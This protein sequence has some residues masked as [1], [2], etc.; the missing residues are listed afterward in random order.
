MS[1]LLLSEAIQ[2]IEFDSLPPA[3]RTFDLDRFSQKKSLWPCQQEALKSALKVLWRYFDHHANYSPNEAPAAMAAR[4]R[5]FLAW[6]RANGLTEE[7]DIPVSEESR[8]FPLISDYLKIVDETIAYD[9][10]INRAGFWMAT[11]SGKSLVL[12]KLIE[13]LWLLV[14]RGEIPPNDILVLTCREDLIAQLKTLVDEFNSGHSAFKIQLRELREFPEAKRESP[15]LFSEME[16]TVFYYRS[17]NLSS[18]QKEKIV[19]FRNYDDDGRWYVLLDEA[20][21]GDRED[22][23]RQHIYSILA[24]NGF[25]FNFSATFADP[26]DLVTTAF[27]F[28][29]SEFTKSGFGKHIS[30]LHQELHAFRDDEDFDDQEKQ[31]IV[32][33][34]LI[35]LTYAGLTERRLA[36]IAAGMY[37]RPLLLT[38]VNSVNTAYSDLELFFAQIRRIAIGEVNSR[39]WARAKAEL[40][41]E[42]RQR[43]SVMFEDGVR[44]SVN[45][46]TYNGIRLPDVLRQVFNAK[47][48]GEIEVIVRPSNNQEIAFKLRTSD[49][50]FAL[51]KIGDISEWLEEKLDGF[52]VEEGFSDEAYFD[53]LNASDSAI[54]ILMGSRSFYEGW[55]SN[56]PNVINFINVGV[57]V[58]SRKFIL[59]AIGR[60]VRVEPIQNLRRRLRP[61][62]NSGDISQKL[63]R[64]IADNVEPLETLFIFGTNRKALHAVIN[65]L[66]QE[67][68]NVG[69]HSI[70]LDKNPLVH[71]REL[72]IP[73][74]RESPPSLGESQRP[75]R[76]EIETAEQELLSRYSNFIGDDRVMMAIHDLTPEMTTRL[77]RSILSPIDTFKHSDRTYG[78]I[79]LLVKH[80]TDYLG[81]VP[82]EFDS[83]FPVSTEICHFENIAVY[84]SD[85]GELK[86]KIENVRRHSE[87]AAAESELD[88]KL[89]RKTI[90]LSKFK[91][92]IKRLAELVRE[93]VVTYRDKRLNIKN[94]A[95]HYYIPLLMSG[96]SSRLDYISHVVQEESEVRFLNGLDQYLNSPQNKFKKF[97]WWMFSKLDE[98]LDRIFIPYYDG[99]MNRIREFVPDFIFWLKAG[100]N[101]DIV[102]VD[103]KGTAHTDYQRKIDGFAKLFE[104]KSGNPKPLHHN[105][106]KV[107][108][109]VF[110]YTSDMDVLPKLYRKYWV[111]NL[112]SLLAQVT[113]PK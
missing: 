43:P 82:R 98:T 77:R 112:D 61:L 27:N 89:K 110:L 94:V 18:E 52:E 111:D 92:G 37:H 54:N 102:F 85:V 70:A 88:L 34:S 46:T 48:H 86:R 96:E 28:N 39:T 40:W 41:E 69:Y 1:R 103:P 71:G 56:R 91:E 36:R 113:R 90:S 35:M 55:D 58:E 8:H 87:V 106:L 60:G 26:R 32:L 104:D 2:A 3:W 59:Q 44:L 101:Y 63:F 19:D 20:H 7:L 23:K 21:K 14:S 84:V 78:D 95:N 12:I 24:R 108:I 72:L 83:L 13:I 45:E 75:G 25:L 79:K 62:F 49:R 50:P 80:L 81:F 64:K 74:Y 11:G 99:S 42:L 22:S 29:L 16:L 107:F 51:I 68:T 53:L 30:I 6:Y 105:G 38:L 4:K 47:S 5:D 109:R 66:H 9:Q 76:F 65:H 93:D 97:D 67:R 31:R 57:G 100:Q 17:D 10:L 33:K 73:S 15:S